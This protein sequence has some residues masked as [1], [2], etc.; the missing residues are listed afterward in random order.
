MAKDIVGMTLL[1]DLY[2]K[3][4]TDRQRDLFELYYQEDLSLG[5]IAENTGITRQGV[6]D[7]IVHAEEALRGFEEAL[8]FCKRQQE[9]APAL[10]EITDAVTRIAAMNARKYYDREIVAEANR[11]MRAVTSLSSEPTL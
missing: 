9:M 10:A 6:R 8:G 11:I 7:A 2:G 1:F 5:E 4:L 3:L